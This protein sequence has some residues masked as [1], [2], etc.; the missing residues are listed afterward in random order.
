MA[1][2]IR[3]LHSHN[4]V[5]RNL[6]PGSVWL[7]ENLYPKIFDFSHSREYLP[8]ETNQT[9]VTNNGSQQFRYQSPEVFDQKIN[10]QYLNSIDIYSL[11]RLMYLMLTGFEPFKYFNAKESDPYFKQGS[12]NLQYAISNGDFPFFPE[13][14][15]ENW[16]ILLTHC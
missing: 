3:Y 5:H 7:D 14:V 16:K 12:L 9:N 15:S 8:D 2:A 1:A 11:G 13:S 4:V 6:N 10:Y